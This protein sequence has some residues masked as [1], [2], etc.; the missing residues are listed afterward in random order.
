MVTAAQRLRATDEESRDR[1]VAG[2]IWRNLSGAQGSNTSLQESYHEKTNLE[3]GKKD[4][5]VSEVNVV[6][7][8]GTVTWRGT[9][10][11]HLLKKAEESLAAKKG[12]KEIQKGRETTR[13]VHEEGENLRL[14]ETWSSLLAARESVGVSRKETKCVQS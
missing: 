2:L 10:G 7:A 12:E 1:A 13:P 3:V 4:F 6:D 8:E 5:H 14:N 9:V 11:L